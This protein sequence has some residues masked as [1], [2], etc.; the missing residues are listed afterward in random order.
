MGFSRYS[1]IRPD[2]LIAAVVTRA[3]DWPEAQLVGQ[4]SKAMKGVEPTE[5]AQM[6]RMFDTFEAAHGRPPHNSTNL[7]RSLKESGRL[8]VWDTS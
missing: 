2:E 4:R 3:Q 1:L 6:L 8:A 5:I 7:G